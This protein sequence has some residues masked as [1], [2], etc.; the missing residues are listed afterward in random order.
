MVLV[1]AGGLGHAGVFDMH[2]TALAFRSAVPAG[3]W[4]EGGKKRLSH[5]DIVRLA[6]LAESTDVA[7]QSQALRALSRELG[8]EATNALLILLSS[9]DAQIRQGASYVLG[10]RR[11][12]RVRPILYSHLMALKPFEGDFSEEKSMALNSVGDYPLLGGPL[13]DYLS[14]RIGVTKWWENAADAKRVPAALEALE[15]ID[16]ARFTALWNQTLISSEEKVIDESFLRMPCCYGDAHSARL[17]VDLLDKPDRRIKVGCL[18]D[19][20]EDEGVMLHDAVKDSLASMFPWLSTDG[21][22]QF[23]RALPADS[24]L[25]DLYAAKLTEILKKPFAGDVNYLRVRRDLLTFVLRRHNPRAVDLVQGE[26]TRIS[27]LPAPSFW[28]AVF[29]EEIASEGSCEAIEILIKG[30]T[31]HEQGVASVCASALAEATGNDLGDD[32]DAWDWWLTNAKDKLHW[33]D[34]LNA[35]APAS[36]WEALAKAALD[37]HLKST[38]AGGK[39]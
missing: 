15:S 2:T 22:V 17:L 7:D 5:E 25:D 24:N 34:H 11:D 20:I 32:H 27:A 6:A 9:K 16:A 37:R 39:H 26:L 13:E 38:G 1:C 10:G 36:D 12:P 4:F 21:A 3:L 18:D 35:F 23:A 19:D 8:Y 31:S 28:D 33:D 14:T 29:A 30:L